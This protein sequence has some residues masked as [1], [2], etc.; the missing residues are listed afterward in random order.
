M[1]AVRCPGKARFLVVSFSVILPPLVARQHPGFSK[2]FRVGFSM[3]DQ[4]F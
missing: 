2:P 3:D 4:C 1:S